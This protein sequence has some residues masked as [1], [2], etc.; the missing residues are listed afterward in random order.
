[1]P[2]YAVCGG[3]VLP[4]GFRGGITSGG[5]VWGAYVQGKCPTLLRSRTRGGRSS[6]A[7]PDVEMR[8]EIEVRQEIDNPAEI[9]VF[10]SAIR[11]GGSG[12][13]RP[14]IPKIASEYVTADRPESSAVFSASLEINANFTTTSLNPPISHISAIN[15]SHLVTLEWDCESGLSG[16]NSLQILCWQGD[17]W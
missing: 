7:I 15:W 12:A 6:T 5:N 13:T 9:R 3:N 17:R 1:M 14:D 8:P 10:M 16:V 11:K 2:T 4:S